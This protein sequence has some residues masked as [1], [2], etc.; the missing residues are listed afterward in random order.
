MHTLVGQT[1]QI[2]QTYVSFAFGSIFKHGNRLSNFPALSSPAETF[3]HMWV[4]DPGRR[5]LGGRKAGHG[6]RAQWQGPGSAGCTPDVQ[7]QGCTGPHSGSQGPGMPGEGACRADALCGSLCHA[8]WAPAS[9]QHGHL[10]A[11]NA[12]MQLHGSFA[13][14]MTQGNLQCSLCNAFTKSVQCHEMRL[15]LEFS[16]SKTITDFDAAQPARL[17]HIPSKHSVRAQ[18]AR[19]RLAAGACT[20]QGCQAPARQPWCWR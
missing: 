6:Q 20:W 14:R 15:Q 4:Y 12:L 1:S 5:G 9:L 10:P 18:M 2:Q 17:R 3:S 8:G 13:L 11:P 16:V 19:G 7:G